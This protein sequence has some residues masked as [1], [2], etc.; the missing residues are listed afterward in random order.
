MRLRCGFLGRACLERSFITLDDALLLVLTRLRGG[1]R[2]LRA[3]H[4]RLLHGHGGL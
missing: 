3:S 2:R 4:R 1:L